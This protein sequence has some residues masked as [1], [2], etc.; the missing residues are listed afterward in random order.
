MNNTTLLNAITS[1]ILPYIYLELQFPRT[2]CKCQPTNYFLQLLTVFNLNSI[3]QLSVFFRDFEVLE[4]MRRE[5]EKE[6]ERDKVTVREK[7][8]DS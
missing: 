4:L 7:E 6:G 5:R 2:R 1:T 3:F 8:R